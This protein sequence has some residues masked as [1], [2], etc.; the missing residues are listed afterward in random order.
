MSAKLPLFVDAEQLN[1]VIGD[2][3]VQIIAVDSASDYDRAHIPG[4][5][6]IAISDFTASAAP[7][8]GLTSLKG[9]AASSPKGDKS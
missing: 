7:V 3:D 4:A 1:A 8:A 6:Q 2:A 9:E 5:L